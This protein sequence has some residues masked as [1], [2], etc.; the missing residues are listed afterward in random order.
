MEG[1]RD[2]RPVFS[3]TQFVCFVSIFLFLFII[4]TPA[5]AQ[6]EQLRNVAGEAGLGTETDVPTLVGRMV[7]VVLQL[8]G[9]I[10]V[11]LLIVGGF[12]WMTSGGNE[13]KIKK[14]KGIITSAVVGLIIVILA[15]TIATFVIERLSEVTA[16]E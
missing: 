15:Y 8:L 3:G 12:M 14:A 9:L 5:F 4:A 13:E 11:V 10:L 6:L 16:P 7:K 1:I 2:S